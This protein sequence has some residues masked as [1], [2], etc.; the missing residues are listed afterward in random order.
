MLR[1]NALKLR[2]LSI[3]VRHMHVKSALMSMG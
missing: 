3:L 2:M 1:L